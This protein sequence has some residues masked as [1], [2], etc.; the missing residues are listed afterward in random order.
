METEQNQWWRQLYGQPD[1]GELR[2]DFRQDFSRDSRCDFGWGL[3]L[4]WLAI[5]GSITR[6][7]TASNLD[8]RVQL[9]DGLGNERLWSETANLDSALLRSRPGT[10]KTKTDKV[11][12]VS[13]RRDA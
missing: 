11:K 9:S 13:A 3:V 5:G 12:L 7:H 8:G 6:H 1:T 4:V 10:S 2:C